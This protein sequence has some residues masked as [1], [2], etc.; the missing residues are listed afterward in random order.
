MVNP[1]DPSA[2]LQTSTPDQLPTLKQ[3]GWLIVIVLG[4]IMVCLGVDA[5][6]FPLQTAKGD[7]T[8]LVFVAGILHM[9]GCGIW[10]TM[11]RKRRSLEVGKW[12]FAAIFL[13]PIAI[14][15]YLILEYKARALLL[16]PVLVALYAAMGFV[17]LFVVF[18]L[19]PL[20]R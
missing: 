4:L 6:H 19:R 18:V 9:L 14:C 11:D 16:L 2:P 5:W 1:I 17:P 20:L 10:I 8:P 12:R 3:E 7:N 13:G 15:C